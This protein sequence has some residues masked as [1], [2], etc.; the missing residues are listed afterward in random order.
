MK[1]TAALSF[2]L[3]AAFALC[4]LTACKQGGGNEFTWTGLE[5]ATVAAGDDYDLMQGVSVTYGG[6]DITSS[7]VVL[8][9]EDN[10]A[11]LTE[12][13][14]YDDYEEFNSNYTGAYTV[15]YRA[16]SGEKYEIKS[17]E[18]TVTQQH[19]V[20]N[21]DFSE[22]NN[23]GFY[24]WMFD[25]P[26]GNAAFSKVTE[27]GTAKPKFT[28]SRLGN[29]WWSLQYISKANLKQ[30][31]TYK[32]TVRAKSTNGKSMAFGFED[33]GNNYAMIKGLSAFTVGTE[34]TDYVSY[35]T[36][37]KDYVNAK[38]VLYL[39]YILE[40]DPAA[41]YDIT[42]D[43]IRIEK[44]EKCSQVTFT[45]LDKLTFKG[46]FDDLKAFIANPKEGVTAKNGD[47]D[48]T[49]K[50][51]VLGEVALNPMESNNFQL[52]YVVESENG[53][54]AIGYRNVT[55]AL[56]KE[57]T[58]SLV[59]GGFDKD[60][61][62]WT[63]DINA[64][65][66]GPD[67]AI[68]E[69]VAGEDNEGAAKITVVKPTGDG[70]RIQ[71]R[72]DVNLE[73]KVHYIITVRAKASIE[74]D[75]ILELNGGTQYTM[76]LTTEYKTFEFAYISPS[77]NSMR[78]SFLLGG[79]GSNNNNSV[80]YI[81][82]AEITLDEDQTEYKDYEMINSN[83]DYGMKNWGYEGA[84]TFTAAKE[85]DDGCVNVHINDN[86]D[87]GWRIQLRQDGKTFDGSKTYKIVVRAKSTVERDVTVEVTGEVGKST[88]FHLTNEVQT[89]EFTFS[90]D[91]DNKTYTSTRVG[92]LLGGAF[93]D[94]TVTVYQFEIVEVDAE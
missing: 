48:L 23:D 7:V 46:G 77:T 71:L 67:G 84:A 29:A 24:N 18:V 87:A 80:I 69:W 70:W 68:M 91:D 38:A 16:N 9:L 10:E 61:N 15:Y 55:V 2:A 36:A 27:N 30:N 31:E 1:K 21:G 6:T 86:T 14:V 22:T 42:L 3:C 45:G 26:G 39:G 73:A 93:K 89:F 37:D 51:K 5:S 75:A 33:V 43:S 72:Q 19:N 17:R 11:E 53:P 90:P 47:T 85:G 78:F 82:S 40:E 92:M 4:G 44:I 83:F 20:A 79:G 88:Q 50:I 12:L 49:D 62:F 74:R 34:F 57:H 81:D 59:N 35:Y 28:V 52:A 8:T 63:V 54:V 66:P 64:S 60:I 94:S 56:A 65:S 32:I 13:G 25:Q 76:N 58:Y 41:S